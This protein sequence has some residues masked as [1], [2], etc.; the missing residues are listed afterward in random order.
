MTIK[1]GTKVLTKI[2][3]HGTVKRIDTTTYSIVLYIIEL[4]DGK[5]CGQNIALSE[6]EIKAV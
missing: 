3:D 5:Y 1:P 2:G 4:T 6:S